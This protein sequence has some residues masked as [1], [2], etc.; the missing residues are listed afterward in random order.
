MSKNRSIGLSGNMPWHFSE[1]LINFKEITNYSPIIMGRKTWNSLPAILPNRKHIIIT[2]NHNLLKKSY[3]NNDIYFT[4]T[5]DSATEL[6]KKL[7]H[8]NQAFII[9]GAIIFKKT[10]HIIKRVYLTI[11]NDDFCGDVYYPLIEDRFFTTKAKSL[12]CV[13]KLQNNN[14]KI[15]KQNYSLDFLTLQCNN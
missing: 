14:N 5:I 6:A 8:T 3:S 11:I 13:N 2:K 10:A 15:K 12:T 4:D 9:G 1:D 7:S